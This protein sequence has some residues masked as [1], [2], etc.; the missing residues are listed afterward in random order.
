MWNSSLTIQAELYLG[1]CRS[2]PVRATQYHTAFV[3]NA[4]VLQNEYMKL[5]PEYI[6]PHYSIRKAA[7]GIIIDASML[8]PFNVSLSIYLNCGNYRFA[9]L[10]LHSLTKTVPHVKSM[11]LRP[12]VLYSYSKFNDFGYH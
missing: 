4:I 8:T 7:S 11:T 10:T 12:E 5:S 2:T 1:A 9:D 6:I 3:Y